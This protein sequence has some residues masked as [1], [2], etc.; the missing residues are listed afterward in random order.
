MTDSDLIKFAELCGLK[1]GKY[2]RIGVYSGIE[3]DDYALFEDGKSYPYCWLSDYHPDRDLNQAVIGLND[4]DAQ[5]LVG[6]LFP[7]EAEFEI[8]MI[9]RDTNEKFFGNPD[10]MAALIVEARLKVAEGG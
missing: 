10:K 8:D 1:V 5:W 4:W 2:K 3:M 6:N 9:L 7:V